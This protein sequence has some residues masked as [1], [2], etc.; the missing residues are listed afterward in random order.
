MK[1]TSFHR[2]RRRRLLAKPETS[3]PRKAEPE[4]FFG[5]HASPMFFQPSVNVTPY[6]KVQREAKEKEK[7]EPA[8]PVPSAK[9]KEEEK[10][11]VSRVP[12]E[13]EEETI[14]RRAKKEEDEEKVQRKN[15]G[16]AIVPGKNVTNYIHSLNSKGKTLPVQAQYFFAARMGYDFSNVKVHTDSQAA[17]SAQ[18]I[19]AKAYAVGNN[20]VFNEGQYDTRS[21]EGK[22]LM[23]HEL[24]HVVQQCNCVGEKIQHTAT[25]NKPA[26]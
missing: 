19:N 8:I 26:E 10:E 6:A 15:S 24:T 14:Q 17:Q 11:K 21:T 20:I 5:E 12:E 2:Y 23:A 3:S 18:E 22:K 13:N 16:P 4:P 7:E 1:P 9:A 25:A